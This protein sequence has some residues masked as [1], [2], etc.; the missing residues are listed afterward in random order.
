[1]K[2]ASPVFCGKIGSDQSPPIWTTTNKPAS[3]AD[4]AGCVCQAQGGFWAS[5]SRM[6]WL[7]VCIRSRSCSSLMQ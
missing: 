1:M 5:A 4:L 6:A 7:Q 3:G 2:R